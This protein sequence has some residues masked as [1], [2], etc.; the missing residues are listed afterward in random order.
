MRIAHAHGQVQFLTCNHECGG[1]V[2]LPSTERHDPF[3]IGTRST[4]QPTSPETQCDKQESG[5]DCSGAKDLYHFVDVRCGDQAYQQDEANVGN[6]VEHGLHEQQSHNRQI[7]HGDNHQQHHHAN[8]KC[9]I[10]PR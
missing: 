10:A 9:K 6:P 2:A 7:A 1:D 8:S 4:E 5:K 3:C